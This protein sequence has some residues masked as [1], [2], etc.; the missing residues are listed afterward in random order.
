MKPSRYQG[1]CNKLTPQLVTSSTSK[2]KRTFATESITRI[3]TNVAN[4]VILW[5]YEN[6]KHFQ[7]FHMF[8]IVQFII[9]MACSYTSWKYIPIFEEDMSWKEYAKKSYLWGSLCFFAAF[10]AIGTTMMIWIFTCKSLKYIILNKGGSS[11]TLVTY[12][13]T[14]GST[15]KIVPL[16]DI[17][18]KKDRNDVGAF[19]SLKVTGTRFFYLVDKDGIFVNPHLYDQTIALDRLSK[20]TP[21][22][23]PDSIL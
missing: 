11:A 21:K 9:L 12:H 2:H 3:N 4:N 13:P 22:T 1:I 14:K 7:R 23:N 17:V 18:I 5:K 8:S 6:P 15:A 16:E 10:A 20:F 19:I